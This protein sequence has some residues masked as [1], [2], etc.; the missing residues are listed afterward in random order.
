LIHDFS[1]KVK[2]GGDSIKG[3][4]G[5]GDRLPVCMD[6]AAAGPFPA[7]PPRAESTAAAQPE[8]A[9]PRSSRQRLHRH[10]RPD[11]WGSALAR[12]PVRR[13]CRLGRGVGVGN[14]SAMNGRNR[15]SRFI[16]A[17]CRYSRKS[18]LVRAR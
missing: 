2:D 18:G 7:L 13:R 12:L 9:L 17:A 1:W 5:M 4:P 15:T 14:G 10:T 16:A 3:E 6:D 8:V 11:G